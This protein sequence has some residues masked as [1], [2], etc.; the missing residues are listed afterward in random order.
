[1]LEAG[2]MIAAVA[3]LTEI[4]SRSHRPLVYMVFPS[5]IWAALRFGSR[6]ATLA[7]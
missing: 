1:V 5:L 2:A 4:P 3:V 6:G 7:I